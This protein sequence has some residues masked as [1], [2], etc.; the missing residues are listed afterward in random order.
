[1]R[2]LQSRILRSVM[3]LIGVGTI[4]F[5]TMIQYVG[6]RMEYALLDNQMR[7]D[8]AYLRE[9]IANGKVGELPHLARTRAWLDAPG[10]AETPPRFAELPV[11]ISHDVEWE[12]SKLHVIREQL[13]E[14]LLTMAVNIDDLE[15]REA[16]FQVVLFVGGLGM[17]LL[18]AALG[19]FISRQIAEP[20]SRMAAELSADEGPKKNFATRYQ[21]MEIEA[22]AKALDAYTARQEQLLEHERNFSSAASH[23]LRTPLTVIRSSLELALL[24][25]PPQQAPNRPLQRA[26]N[27]AEDLG[28]TLDGLLAL[29][30][31]M[32][33]SRMQPTRLDQVV[34]QAVADMGDPAKR[35]RIQ[36]D[37]LPVKAEMLEAHWRAV[38]QNLLGNAL[39]H[40]PEGKVQ[41]HLTPQ[42][43][44]VRDHGPGFPAELLAQG[45]GARRRG[46]ESEGHGLGLY[47]VQAVLE[48]YGAS[49]EARNH[50]DGGAEVTITGLPGVSAH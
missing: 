40:A 25:A 36:L 7:D 29:A 18:V 43:L 6:E 16:Q 9:Q 42:G 23:E 1:M 13:A 8:S 20:I 49:L 47:I 19:Y 38:C 5:I 17:C 35:T 50:P 12:G 4:I 41:V 30:R 32:P 37:L 45:F 3:I 48:R 2:T 46:K 21:G 39:R 10:H 33:D 14:G 11:G 15:H 44:T 26:L 24:N 27:A 34:A 28:D 31:E 22:I